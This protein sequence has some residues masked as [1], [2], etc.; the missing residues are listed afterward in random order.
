[1]EKTF[2][3][4]MLVIFI[5]IAV[6]YFCKKRHIVDTDFCRRLSDFVIR[7]ACPCLIL[8]SVVG[9]YV[10]RRELVLPLLLVGFAT[11]AVLSAVGVALPRL[12]CRQS[13]DKGIYGFMLAFGNIG[14]I[15]YP[16]VSSLFGT[17][18]VFYASILMLPYTVF[19]FTV[20][21]WFVSGDKRCVHLNRSI[22]LSPMMSASLIAILM[23]CLNVTN[24]PA[25]V[26]RSLVL[27]G[28]ITVPCALLII[29]ASLAD[30]PL[31]SLCSKPSLFVVSVVR[32]LVVPL[33]VYVLTAE[34]GLDTTV[35]NINT[36]LTAMPVSTYGTMFCYKFHRDD[37]LMTEG[38][39]LSTLL[40]IISVPVLVHFI[41]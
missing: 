5:L 40:S 11:H 3:S 2:T 33:C 7:I 27:V 24:V 39:C 26:S 17:E 6:G 22:L 21:F 9:S 16:V 23:V 4:Q 41:S 18:A 1:M 25:V 31:M 20:G 14:F 13:P 36:V 28:G 38:T 8:S 32:L 37:A 10:P 15:G 34:A 19:A 35:N 12:A 29:G 30:V